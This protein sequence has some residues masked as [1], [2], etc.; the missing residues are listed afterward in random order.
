MVLIDYNSP[1]SEHIIFN[2]DMKIHDY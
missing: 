2:L 1:Y